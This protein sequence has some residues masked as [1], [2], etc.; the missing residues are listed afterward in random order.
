MKQLFKLCGDKEELYKEQQRQHI[1]QRRDLL[2]LAGAGGDDGVG[3]ERHTDA[4]TDRAGDGHEDE[5]ERNGN[6]LENVVPVDLF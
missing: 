3:D 4:V 1:G 6:G 2:C 5:H